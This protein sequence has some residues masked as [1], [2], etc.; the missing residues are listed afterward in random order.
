MGF[1]RNRS[2]IYSC[3]TDKMAMFKKE[4]YD[5]IKHRAYPFYG[6]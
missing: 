4:K 3:F 2:V 5:R 1:D 6:G